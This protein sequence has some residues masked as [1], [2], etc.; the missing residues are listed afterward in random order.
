MEKAAT[1]YIFSETVRK[2]RWVGNKT[3]GRTMLLLLVR[4]IVPSSQSVDCRQ[5]CSIGGANIFV[6]RETASYKWKTKKK[7]S[8]LRR[9]VSLQTMAQKTCVYHI[10]RLRERLKGIVRLTNCR[11]LVGKNPRDMVA[12]VQ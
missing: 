10:T 6:V 4:S 7:T 11:N 2:R 5:P 3:C 8:H 1:V 9:I 12:H